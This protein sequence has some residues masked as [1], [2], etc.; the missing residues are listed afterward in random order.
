MRYVIGRK[1]V[2]YYRFRHIAIAGSWTGF[3]EQPNFV[4]ARGA[5]EAVVAALTATSEGQVE[6]GRRT[7]SRDRRAVRRLH[8]V[9]ELGDPDRGG[10]SRSRR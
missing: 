10:R 6:G 5:T 8:P 4:D 7:A 1:G 3:S 2:A 9:R